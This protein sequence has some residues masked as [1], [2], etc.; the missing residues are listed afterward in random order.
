MIS[1]SFLESSKAKNSLISWPQ[2]NLKNWEVGV[3]E[4]SDLNPK[5]I[6][7]IEVDSGSTISADFSKKG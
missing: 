2:E 5:G 7:K 4:V 6:R 1:K 3:W